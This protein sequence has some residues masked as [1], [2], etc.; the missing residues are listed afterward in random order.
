VKYPLFVSD[1]E[2]TW[3]FCDR[4]SK[5]KSSNIKFHEIRPVGAEFHADGRTVKDDDAERRFFCSFADAPKNKYTSKIIM[6]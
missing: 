5:K 4:F 6:D 3:N 2:K 1:F